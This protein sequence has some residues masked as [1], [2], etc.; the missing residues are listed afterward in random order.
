MNVNLFSN[1]WQQIHNSSNIDTPALMIYPDRVKKNI[2]SMIEIAGSPSRLRPHLKTHKMGEVI[3]LQMNQGI[4]KFKCSTIAEAELLA[5]RGAADILLAYPVVGSAVRRYIQLIK[6]YPESFFSAITDSIESL[7][8][9]S[10]AALS[11]NMKLNLWI[12]IN[13]GMNRSGICADDHAYV[14]FKAIEDDKNTVFSG[15]HVYDGHIHDSKLIKRKK[16][17]DDDYAPVEILIEKIKNTSGNPPKVIAGGSPTFPIHAKRNDVELG[18]GTPV[19]WDY[20][21]SSNYEDLPFL[22]AALVLCRVVSIPDSKSICLDL[23]HKAIASEMVPPRVIFPELPP[24]TI[25]IHSE[26]H[27]VLRFKDQHSIKIA[28]ELYGIPYHICPTVAKY[29]NAEVIRDGLCVGTWDIEA[30]KRKI[31]I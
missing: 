11:Q 4:T 19:F 1:K 16:H 15:L 22:H 18:P 7:K 21:Y 24:Y 5:L 30:R 17:C 26:E 10:A 27:L 8:I 28:S 25:A 6:K 14:L 9:I 20:G 13:N 29:D 31:S 2:S 3:Q 12:D 23:G